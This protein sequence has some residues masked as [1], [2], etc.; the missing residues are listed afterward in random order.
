MSTMQ[1]NTAADQLRETLSKPIFNTVLKAWVGDGT[2]DYEVY[3]RTPELLSLQTAVDELTDSDELMFQ[4]VHQAQEVWLKLLSHELAGVVEEVDRDALWAAAARLDRANR[5]AECLARE[6]RVLETMT[7]DTYQI[8]R[9]S[10]GK[11]SG[12]ESPGYN[13][14]LTAAEHVAAVLDR[15]LDRREVELAQVYTAD[16]QPDLKRLC[17][18]LV[19]FDER[20]QLWL[21][22]HFMLVRRTIGV[23][24]GVNALDGVP[25]RVLTG[26]MTKPLF[27][28]LWQVRGELTESWRRE[29]GYAPGA[30]RRSTAR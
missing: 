15:L 27:R 10:L 6:I 16:A 14:V 29:G 1:G 26:R 7:P 9:R 2:T 22:S 30:T 12:Q 8:I 25:T 24:Q 11:G 5:I 20:F 4:I 21:V 23:G 18:L 3:L 17:E 13:A 28:A 19:D